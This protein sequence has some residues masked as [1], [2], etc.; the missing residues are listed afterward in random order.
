MHG[1]RLDSSSVTVTQIFTALDT[2]ILAIYTP[3]LTVP[4]IGVQTSWSSYPKSSYSNLLIIFDLRRTSDYRIITNN[5]NSN[6]ISPARFPACLLIHPRSQSERS[7]SKMILLN[8]ANAPDQCNMHSLAI[9]SRA[10][11]IR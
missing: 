6:F 11:T 10:K 2:R 3:I 7:V 1:S 9:R 5:D 8:I 4:D